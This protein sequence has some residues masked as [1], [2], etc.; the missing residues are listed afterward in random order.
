MP[1]SP[2]REGADMVKTV[3]AGG[4]ALSLVIG[5]VALAHGGTT[6]AISKPGKEDINTIGIAFAMNSE[7]EHDRLQAEVTL[8]RRVGTTWVVVPYSTAVTKWDAKVFQTQVNFNCTGI[9]WGDDTY[10]SKGEFYWWEGSSVH[11][12]TR[13]SPSQVIHDTTCYDDRH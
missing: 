10:R 8:Q 5:G 11:K 2:L 7:F 12:K 4:M 13:F 3:V 9:T 6:V 1:G